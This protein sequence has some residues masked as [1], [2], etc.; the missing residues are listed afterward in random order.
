MFF[1]EI[2]K[3][4]QE[5]F[6]SLEMQIIQVILENKEQMRQMTI[7]DLAQKSFTSKSSVLRFTQKLGFNGY[8]DFKVLIDWNKATGSEMGKITSANVAASCE[9]FLAAVE[10]GPHLESFCDL[11]HQQEYVYLLATSVDQQLQADHLAKQFLNLGKHIA[12]IPYTPNADISSRIIEGLSGK[13]LI[14]VFSH[15]GENEFL[16]Q[17]LAIPILRKVPIISFTFEQKNWLN[18][19]ATAHFHIETDSFVSHLM[20]PSFIHI[21]IDFLVYQYRDYLKQQESN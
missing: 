13:D 4:K 8:A 18:D 14:I 6:T 10:Q 20:Y 3:K 16:K 11:I 15:T 9:K 17:L 7:G 2:I 1:E 5:N 21:I 19:H 12:K